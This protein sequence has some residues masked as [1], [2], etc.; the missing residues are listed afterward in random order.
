MI[1]LLNKLKPITVSLY[2]NRSCASTLSLL[3]FLTECVRE[4]Q[5]NHVSREP[6]FGVRPLRLPADPADLRPA[7]AGVE[8]LCCSTG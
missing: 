8:G 4:H 5:S 6:T 1:K 2:F 7:G 3:S